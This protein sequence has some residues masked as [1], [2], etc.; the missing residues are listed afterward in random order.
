MKNMKNRKIKSYIVAILILA[1]LLS[2]TACSSGSV[3]GL[4]NEKKIDVILWNTNGDKF[5]AASGAELMQYAAK[6]FESQTDISVNLISIEANNQEDFFKKRIEVMLSKDQPEMIL[7]NT[8][9][10]DELLVIE[11]MKNELVPMDEII[12]NSTDVFEGMK[13]EHYSAIAVLVYGNVM[14]NELVSA[15]GY[16]PSAVFMT[17]ED[18]ED[19]YLRWAETEG[20]ELN[21]FDYNIFSRLGLTSKVSIED[22]KVSLDHDQIIKKI[23][24]NKTFIT[25]LPERNLSK[26]DVVG[27]S[28]GQNKVLYSKE[29]D[30]LLATAHMRPVNFLTSVSFNAFD[31]NDFSSNIN[32]S[33]S[34]FAM[35][36]YS[37]MSSIGF[38]ILD[39]Q[40]KDQ[41]HAMAFANFLL[42]PE[43]QTDMQNFTT[44]SPKMSGSVLKSVNAKQ[45]E[46]A[47]TA[48]DKPIQESVIDAHSR[49]SDQLNKP[50]AIHFS[51]SSN[52][53]IVALEE[54]VRI[55]T[56]HIWGET[57]SN[58][59]L[60]T[61]LKK[62]ESSL[63]LMIN[64]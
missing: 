7:F 26:E 49:M 52:I 63:N 57:K 22:N 25:S 2:F 48:T 24:K 46:V 5:P 16:D 62:L 44:K 50:S 61:E 42:S 54:I 8:R 10:Q 15:F 38:G 6:Q 60:I 55:S 27:F 21:L 31:M 23:E 28:K 18:V 4:A 19:L 51:A 43:F 9:Y 45:A 3:T 58:D 40:S 12:E 35:G 37:Q 56:E 34:G 20:A 29:R 33:A 59:A 47:Q 39:N 32:T 11:S 64:E 13:G 1:I 41:E 36:D 53:S 14:N 17:S 30:A